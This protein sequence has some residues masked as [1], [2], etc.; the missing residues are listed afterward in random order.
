LVK[1][2]DPETDKVIKTLP[3]KELQRLH[4][5]IKEA[6]GILFDEEV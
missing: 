5:K 3:P 2:I 4:H 1:V 6:M